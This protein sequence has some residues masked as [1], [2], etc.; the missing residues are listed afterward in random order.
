VV[1]AGLGIIITILFQVPMFY[2]KK[3]FTLIELLVIIVIIGILA[4]VGLGNYM[5]SQVKARDAKRKSDL[6]QIQKALEMYY[7]DK[8]KY[9]L[10]GSLPDEVGKIMGCEVDGDEVCEWGD[11]WQG[12]EVI[13]I[14]EMPDDPRG[15]YCYDSGETDYKLYA[16]LENTK[17]QSIGSYVCGGDTYNYGVSSPNITP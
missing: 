6:S 1:A 13:Y 12:S 8:G 9:P 17:D 10:S 15:Q 5:S 14:K 2:K 11:S 7:N 3:A 16:V 4:T